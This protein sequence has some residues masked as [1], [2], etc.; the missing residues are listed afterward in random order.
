MAP[1]RQLPVITAGNG[2]AF[3]STEFTGLPVGLEHLAFNAQ[4]SRE[5]VPL[6]EYRAKS[7]LDGFA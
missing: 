4:Y 2:F 5:L 7:A 3:R 1:P 6:L